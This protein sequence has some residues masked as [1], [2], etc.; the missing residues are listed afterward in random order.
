[1]LTEKNE[2]T[3][4]LKGNGVGVLVDGEVVDAKENEEDSYPGETEEEK[5]ASRES[6]GYKPLRVSFLSFSKKEGILELNVSSFTDPVKSKFSYRVGGL[7]DFK[8]Q[9]DK[10]TDNQLLSAFRTFHITEQFCRL[11]WYSIHNDF[12][13]K[14]EA[15]LKNEVKNTLYKSKVDMDGLQLR[16]SDYAKLA[17]PNS[18]YYE[19][20]MEE[21]SDRDREIQEKLGYKTEKK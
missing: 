11:M 5:D 4:N 2:F 1:M 21:L 14:E 13:D 8:K 20:V 6:D 18:D 9:Y 10:I 16:Y 15:K 17:H 19:M 3:F 12:E 7:N